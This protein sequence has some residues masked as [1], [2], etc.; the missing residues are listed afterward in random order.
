MPRRQWRRS[1]SVLPELGGRYN[2]GLY[3]PIMGPSA[4]VVFADDVMKGQSK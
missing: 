2:P 3:G 1:W 4:T